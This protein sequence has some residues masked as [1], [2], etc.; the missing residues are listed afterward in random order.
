MVGSRGRDWV[1]F[2]LASRFNRPLIGVRSSFNSGHKIKRQVQCRLVPISAVSTCSKVHGQIPD[3]PT[4]WEA[5]NR[6]RS[7]D[8]AAIISSGGTFADCD[9]E[10]FEIELPLLRITPMLRTRNYN[11]CDIP[12]TPN[13]FLCLF[14]L[15][16]VRIT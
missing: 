16:H 5:H 3:L 1:K 12:Q 10:A 6:A 11:G 7:E 2:S 13:N 4:R 9:A 15:P 14:E 8:F